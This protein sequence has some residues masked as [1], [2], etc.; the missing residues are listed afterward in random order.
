MTASCGLFGSAYLP[1]TTW[2][3]S[4]VVYSPPMAPSKTGGFSPG[5]IW[6]FAPW[7]KARL[8]LNP[9]TASAPRTYGSRRILASVVAL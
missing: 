4:W 5:R 1:A 2:A 9:T 8:P 7:T 6:G 3:L